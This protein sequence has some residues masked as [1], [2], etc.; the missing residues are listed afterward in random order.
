MPNKNTG[1]PDVYA[2]NWDKYVR[3]HFPKVK[4][5]RPDLGW[6]GDEWGSESQWTTY[7]ERLI[8]DSLPQDMAWALEIGGGAGKYTVRTLDRF[9]H[10]RIISCDVS[11][12]Y[13]DV[14][15]E[16]CADHVKRG[17]LVPELIEPSATALTD[18]C[19]K[20]DLVGKL[21][22][23]FS[24][25]AMVHVDLQYL[26]SYWQE[27]AQLLRP[28]GKLIMTVADATSQRGTV[29]LLEDISIYFNNSNMLGKFEWISP[30][31][32]TTVL[33]HIGFDVK[34]FRFARDCG[35]VATKR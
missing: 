18:A 29:K 32:V 20:H 2:R 34:I 23:V 11:A 9:P 13:L 1:A 22:A 27:S 3:Q 14:L 25:D 26:A 7:F 4:E 31:I 17:R 19:R 16:R 15:R 5:Q 35:F 21:D 33:N 6:P 30:D 28:G 24:I 12:A 8:A 10:A